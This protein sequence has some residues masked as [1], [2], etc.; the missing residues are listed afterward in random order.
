VDWAVFMLEE[1]YDTEHLRMLASLGPAPSPADVDYYFGQTVQE[2]NWVVPP[3]PILLRLYAKD[4]AQSILEG[5]VQPENGCHE[6][7]GI[8][9][10]LDHPADMKSWLYLDDNL[11]PG[12][13]EELEGENWDV[14]IRQEA[15]RFLQTM[16][17]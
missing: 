5:T 16:G 3:T 8:Y 13:Y 4:I 17:M 1:G 14:A 15:W 12:T 7:Y 11:E 10:D 2:L 6:I 9:R